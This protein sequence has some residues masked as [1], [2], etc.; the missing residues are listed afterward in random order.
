MYNCNNCDNLET[1]YFEC[2]TCKKK[3]CRKC[4]SSNKHNC[5]KKNNNDYVLNMFC[6]NVECLVINN[7]RLC[8]KCKK[9]F[10]GNHF[11][12]HNCKKNDCCII[13]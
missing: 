5:N 2:N 7:L 8:K 4:I 3:L 6:D 9:K 11:N 12:N 13:C 10:C 1:L